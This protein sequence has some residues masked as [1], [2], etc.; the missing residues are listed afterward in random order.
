MAGDNNGKGKFASLL[1]LFQGIL[2]ILFV[3]FIDYGNE[4]L[5]ADPGAKSSSKD[6]N[7]AS[8]IEFFVF[9][10]ICF[11]NGNANGCNSLEKSSSSSSIANFLGPAKT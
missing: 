2:L 7:T 6:V 10:Y 4:L 11:I 3:V 1:L 8:K 5:P 9:N